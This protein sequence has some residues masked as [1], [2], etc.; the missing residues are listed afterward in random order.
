MSP[1]P[2]GQNLKVSALVWYVIAT[3]AGAVRMLIQPSRRPAMIVLFTVALA[4]LHLGYESLTG[5]VQSHHLLNR[6]DMPALS[7]WLGLFTLPLLG[8][9][10]AARVRSGA[11]WKPLWLALVG[12][13]V[14]GAMLAGAF[15]LGASGV[16]QA[17]FFGLFALAVQ[18]PLYRAEHVLGF[19]VGM[20]FTFG[21][22]LP[23]IIGAV[24]A[25]LSLALRG[26]MRGVVHVWRWL[27]RPAGRPAL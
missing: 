2:P 24:F 14:Y 27:A 21:A 1:G 9:I 11:P 15:E 5:G 20:T 18:L 16:T 12:A 22:V 23:T 8:V 3:V 25:T 6:R 13:A 4:V 19:V 26:A 17:L 10:V 7:N